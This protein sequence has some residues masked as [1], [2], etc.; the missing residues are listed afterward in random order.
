MFSCQSS[1]L[2]STLLIDGT[3]RGRNHSLFN[4]TTDLSSGGSMV[5]LGHI[6]G[7]ILQN[8]SAV[9]SILYRIVRG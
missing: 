9:H 7:S 2:A 5:C 4:R 1:I 3:V 6:C 8:H